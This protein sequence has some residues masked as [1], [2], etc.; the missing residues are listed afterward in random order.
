[1]SKQAFKRVIRLWYS[2]DSNKRMTEWKRRTQLVLVCRTDDDVLMNR[3]SPEMACRFPL[4]NRDIA[5]PQSIVRHD[6]LC[7]LSVR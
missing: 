2:S 7:S 6:R 3:S 1:M 5:S 4:L